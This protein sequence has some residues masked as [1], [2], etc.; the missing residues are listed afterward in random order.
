M[1]GM[2]GLVW[3]CLAYMGAL[4]HVQY[5]NHSEQRRYCGAEISFLQVNLPPAGHDA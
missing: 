5:A 1:V 3:A 2:N 4:P